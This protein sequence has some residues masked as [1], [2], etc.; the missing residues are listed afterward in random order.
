M[1][2]NTI[3]Y[4]LIIFLIVVNGFFLF[5]YMAKKNDVR[6]HE[7]QRDK[8][9]IVN[10]LGFNAEQLERFNKNSE[11]HHETM[12][13]LSDSIKDLKDKMFRALSDDS[14]SESTVD[15]ISSLICEKGKEKEKEVFYH[16]KMIKEISND[17]QKEKFN[18]ILL[19]ALQ[20]GN[21]GNRPPPKGADGRRPRPKKEF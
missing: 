1:N 2:K 8:N 3:L 4:T 12:M 19:D 21:R 11:G 16:F 9:F 14:I 13:R 18:S 5:E 10:E 20:K 6:P 17:E 7:P 15:S